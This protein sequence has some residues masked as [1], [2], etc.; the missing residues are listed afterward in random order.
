MN[1]VAYEMNVQY[2]RYQKTAVWNDQ[3]KNQGTENQTAVVTIAWLIPDG[4]DSQ[5][6]IAFESLSF[7]SMRERDDGVDE[8]TDDRQQQRADQTQSP[9]DLH[10]LLR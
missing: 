10:V 5:R 2:A 6:A 3:W 8:A 4:C 1:W 9:V 7:T